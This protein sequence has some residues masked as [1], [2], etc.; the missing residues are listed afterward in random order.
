MRFA[1]V[2]LDG[3]ERL[4][5]QVDQDSVA[6]A[7]SLQRAL[8]TMDDLLRLNG[9]LAFGELK[10]P[11]TGRRIAISSLEWLPV[12]PRPQKILAVALNNNAA[13]AVL[14]FRSPVPAYFS[15]VVSSLQGHLKPIRLESHYGL[16]HPEPELGVIIGKDGRN[17]SLERALDHVI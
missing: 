14:T 3:L 17:L 9:D 10:V 6:V 15:K 12:V 11:A 7:T 8:R 5:V 13:D 4:V 1:S 16:T 2:I